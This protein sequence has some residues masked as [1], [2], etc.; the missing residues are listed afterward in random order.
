VRKSLVY[1]FV[2][3]LIAGTAY[4]A[5]GMWG[6]CE[7][8]KEPLGW[9]GWAWGTLFEGVKGE[10]SRSG[11]LSEPF[12]RNLGYPLY[13]R[14]GQNNNY[15]GVEWKETYY[16]FEDEKLCAVVLIPPSW[17]RSTLIDY[18]APSNGAWSRT[19]EK[20]TGTVF[21]KWAKGAEASLLYICELNG[22]GC[23]IIGRAKTVNLWI[24]TFMST[25]SGYVGYMKVNNL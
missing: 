7:M 24:D 25:H 14:Q 12:I 5:P 13:T 6:E 8:E 17:G 22:V 4:G 3:L 1:V 9:S 21:Y 19:G 18:F 11:V 15:L 2:F 10:L 20:D 23:L 16:V